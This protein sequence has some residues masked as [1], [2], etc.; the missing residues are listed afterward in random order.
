MPNHVCSVSM[1][2][3]NGSQL[4]MQRGN[5][6]LNYLVT[7]GYEE[8]LTYKRQALSDCFI[9]SAQSLIK[10][11]HVIGPSR[12]AHPK[13][14]NQVKIDWR[15]FRIVAVISGDRTFWRLD[16]PLKHGQSCTMAHTMRC[17]VK[18]NNTFA[19]LDNNPRKINAY[20]WSLLVKL[21]KL[22]QMC[23][24]LV[25]QYLDSLS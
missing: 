18:I 12:L 25:Q 11:L 14:V 13:R 6:Q 19:T 24:G 2:I 17:A 4:K 16:H 10:Y 3:T 1:Y 5:H 15:L 21:Q 7:V 23:Q 22:H 9:V 20:W 8:P